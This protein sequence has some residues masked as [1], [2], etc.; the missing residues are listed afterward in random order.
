MKIGLD[1]YYLISSEKSLETYLCDGR[2]DN[3]VVC[4]GSQILVQNTGRSTIGCSMISP[5]VRVK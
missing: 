3:R 2:S 1:R 5:S 4:A